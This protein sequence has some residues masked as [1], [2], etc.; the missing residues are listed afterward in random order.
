MPATEARARVL[1]VEDDPPIRNALDVSLRAAGYH[2]R[3]EE[4]GTQ[5]EQVLEEFGPDLAI[6]DVRLRN[7]PDGYTV[8]RMLRGR[9]DIPILFL[10]A[11]DGLTARLEGFRVGGDDYLAKPYELEELKARVEALLRRSGRLGSAIWRVGD[12]TVDPE[13][14][15]VTRA[16]E[17]VELTRT[18]FELLSRLVQNPGRVMSKTQLLTHVWGYD[19]YDTHLVQKHM[20]S[21]CRKLDTRG[22]RVIETVRGIGYRLRP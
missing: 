17:P 4:D 19:A 15:V 8:A 7:G 12:T 10:T 13:N 22:P 18:E 9:S 16:G 6:L 14:R 3:A 2:V 21:L 11:A 5:T 20:S 1:V